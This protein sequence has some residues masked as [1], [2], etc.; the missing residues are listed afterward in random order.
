LLV[1]PRKLESPM[2][3]ADSFGRIPR[4]LRISVT[5][6]C[7]LRCEF[8]MPKTPIWLPS[9]DILTYEEMLRVVSVCAKMGVEKIRLSGGEPLIRRDLNRL[10]RMLRLI[11][12][13]NFIGVTTNGILL[14]E[15]AAALKEAGLD[16]VTI[17]LHSLKPER[18]H[19]ITGGGRI[20][21][22]FAG[23]DAAKENKFR[24]IK[25]NSV[26]QRGFNDDEILDLA[27][28]AFNNDITLR[29]IEFMP[30][31]GQK[32][33]NMERVVSGDEI[34]QKIRTRYKILPLP[35][36]PSST[37]R[38]Y[39]FMH[40]LGEI[41]IITSITEPFCS[42]C[43]RIR[44]AANGRILTCLFDRSSYDL[45]PLLRGGATDE[46]LSDTISYAVSKKAPGVRTLLQHCSNL[47]HVRAM[48]T[49]GG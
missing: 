10:V 20:D 36:E 31:D 5:D 43:D 13:I 6:R 49:I 23:I 40:G 11:P 48:H 3:M 34:V 30:F 4:K 39:K 2:V 19:T 16:G 25:I 22:A 21:N 44:L 47:E 42:D 35:R 37:A 15:Q 8:C 41:G 14:P 9:E 46:E 18:Y 27:A 17:S 32:S 29:F 33:W 45:R 1:Y 28:L 24:V 38:V 26:I 12:G 7:N